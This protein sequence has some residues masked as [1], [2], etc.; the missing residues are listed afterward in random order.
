M[1]A[2]RPPQPESRNPADIAREAFRMMATRRIAPTP[3]AYRAAYLEITGA[4]QENNAETVLTQFAAHLT[5]NG[6]DTIDFGQRLKRTIQSSDWR[7]CSKTLSLLIERRLNQKSFA[8]TNIQVSNDADEAQLLRVL[9]SRTLTVAVAALVEGAPDLLTEAEALGLAV[10]E[11]TNEEE[12]VRIASRLK[13]LCYR[14]ETR[15]GELSEQQEMMRRLLALLLEN[16]SELL[17]D[18][19]WLSGQ[20]EVVRQLIAGQIDIGMLD[21]ATKSLKEIIYKQ[22]VVKHSLKEAKLTLKNMM[23]TFVDRLGTI[24]TKTGDYNEKMAKYTEKIGRATDI[25]TLHTILDEVMRETQSVHN[26]TMQAR[27]SILMAQMEVQSAELR[28]QQLEAELDA[29][30]EK[31]REDQLTGSLNRR[32]LEEAFD[33]EVA[34]SDRSGAPLSI[35]MLDIDNFKDLND[36]HG[37]GVGDDALIHLVDIIKQTLRPTDEVARYGGEEFLILLPETSLEQ[38]AEILTRVQRELTRRFFMADEKRL[39]ITFSAGIALRIPP[40]N[41]EALTQRADEAMYQAKR[42]G[43]NQVVTAHPALPEPAS[44]ALHD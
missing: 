3:D 34:R 4:G 36:A 31:L 40:E 14:I 13:Q 22:S 37:H 1:Q 15:S 30:S 28:I 43:K 18:D 42:E 26:E 44:D 35:A 24:A 10:K 20:V 16:I 38:A 23:I 7:E 2:S 21:S 19:S 17:D 29:V 5:R 32:G 12:L 27:E 8:Q 39:V 6:G 33:R 41:L 25:N 11:A 9:L